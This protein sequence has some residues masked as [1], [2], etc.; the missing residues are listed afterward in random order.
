MV[1]RNGS[2]DSYNMLCEKIMIKILICFD[3]CQVTIRK[4][5]NYFLVATKHI[6]FFMYILLWILLPKLVDF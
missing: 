4:K 2:T 3:I 1:Y 5:V 6:L